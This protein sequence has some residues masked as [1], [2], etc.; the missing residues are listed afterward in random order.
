MG[1]ACSPHCQN[2]IAETPR[3]CYDL[4]AFVA[5]ESSL[6]P[7]DTKARRA[8]AQR[9]FFC[10]ASTEFGRQTAFGVRNRPLINHLGAGRRG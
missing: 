7:K 4:C 3:L 1:F 6:T 5:H 2:A 9:A 10:G 8:N